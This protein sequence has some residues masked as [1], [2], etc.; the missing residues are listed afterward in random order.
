MNR[1]PQD[2]DAPHY[3]PSN[4]PEGHAYSIVEES[5]VPLPSEPTDGTPEP[6]NGGSFDPYNH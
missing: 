6:D 2:P 5:F 1:E 4:P 3:T